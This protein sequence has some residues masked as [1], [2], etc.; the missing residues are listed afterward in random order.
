VRPG[1]KRLDNSFIFAITASRVRQR[2]GA[3]RLKHGEDRSRVVVELGAYRI[4]A[5][6]ELDVRHVG[7]AHDLAVRAGLEHDVAELLGRTQPALCVDP[8]SGSR[9][10]P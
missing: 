1:G 7:E 5:A 6:A 4:V 9:R 10:R 2:I 3:R 8:R